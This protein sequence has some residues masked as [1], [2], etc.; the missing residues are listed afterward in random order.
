MLIFLK[1]HKSLGLVFLGTKKS[2]P[3]L[4]V[5]RRSVAKGLSVAVDNRSLKGN[6]SPKTIGL[7]RTIGRRQ[8]AAEL[9]F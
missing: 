7:L 3:G 9:K 2:A 5:A 6:R 4:S 8:S 1:P